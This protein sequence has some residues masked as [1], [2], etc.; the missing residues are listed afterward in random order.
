MEINQL[1]NMNENRPQ[2]VPSGL[3]QPA[4]ESPD[5]RVIPNVPAPSSSGYLG[6]QSREFTEVHSKEEEELP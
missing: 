3:P 4:P 5:P 6:D 1:L 2:S